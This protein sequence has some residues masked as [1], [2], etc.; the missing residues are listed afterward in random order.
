LTLA[1]PLLDLLFDGKQHRPPV[2]VSRLR[3]RIH[4]WHR[5]CLLTSESGFWSLALREE[6]ST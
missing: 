1:K 3:P 4:I 2:V 6:L 5:T